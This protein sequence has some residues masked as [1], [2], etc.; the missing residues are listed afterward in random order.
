MGRLAGLGWFTQHG[1]VAA[2][3]SLA[4]LLEEPALRDALM[5]RIGELAGTDLGTVRWFHAEVVHDDLARPDLEG[6]DDRGQ[7]LVVVEA[8]FGASLTPSQIQAY[9]THQLTKLDPGTR[10]ALIVLVPTYR[11]A[12]AEAVLST[13]GVEGDG[14]MAVSPSVS[15]S[16][17]TWD[18]L[19]SVWEG[20]I[21]KLPT[22]DRD[23]IR[24][25]LWQF[26]GLCDTMVG[27]DVPPLSTVAT[28]EGPWQER[29]DELKRLVDQASARLYS[30]SKLPPIGTE[31]WPEFEYYRRYLPEKRL[32][33]GQCSLGVAGGLEGTPFWFRYHQGTPNFRIFRD[34]IRASRFSGAARGDGGHVWLPLRV[35]PD[36]SGATIV[37]ELIEEIEA[38]RAVAEGPELPGDPNWRR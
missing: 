21:P 20:A 31:R 34:R 8:K 10:G 24:C 12:E 29:E 26:R 35:S 33:G 22:N 1:E 6:W 38:I 4:V 7:P 28:G 11:R 14:T 18:D 15:T 23:V 19:L 37:G 27:L 13:V 16:I 25:D 36:R 5:Q 2:T 17:L 30:G 32:G 3:Q 9:L